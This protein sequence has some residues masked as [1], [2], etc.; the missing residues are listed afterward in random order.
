MHV[1]IQSKSSP[2]RENHV[3]DFFF[4]QNLLFDAEIL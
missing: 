2:N 1:V 3:S 4:F